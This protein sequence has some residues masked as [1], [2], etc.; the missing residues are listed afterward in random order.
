MVAK[1]RTPQPNGQSGGNVRRFPGGGQN[2]Q[3]ANGRGRPSQGTTLVN[4][5]RAEGIGLF[6]TPEGQAFARVPMGDHRE[7]WAL[8]STGLRLWLERLH[9]QKTRAAASAQAVKEA[10]GVLASMALYDGQEHPV[11]LRTAAHDG[12]IY[13]DLAN[14]HWEIVEIGADIPDGWRVVQALDAPVRFRR[15]KGM[16]ALPTPE[17]GGSLDELRPFINVKDEDWILAKGWLVQAARPT[18]PYISLLLNGEQGTA[19]TSTQEKLRATFDPH[20]HPLRADP[21]DERDMAVGAVNNR[22]LGFDN[23]S[24]LQDWQSDAF[25]R[26]ATG[27]GYATRTLYANDEETLLDMQRPVMLNGIGELASRADLMDRSIV[28][29]T[30]RLTRYRGKADIA[31][32]FAAAHPAILGALCTA[33]A[34]ALRELPNV[35]TSDL[36][37][38]A[39]AAAFVIAAEQAGT[40]GD[41]VA[42]TFKDAYA[43]NRALVNDSALEANPVAQAVL[44]FFD[45]PQRLEPGYGA[46][47]YGERRVS[48]GDVQEWTGTIARLGELL[49]DVTDLDDTL[50][51]AWPKSGKGWGTAL[52][53]AAPN[54]RRKGI[55]LDF[56]VP[57]DGATGRARVGLTRT[58]RPQGE[59]PARPETGTA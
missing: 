51:K 33:L 26:M 18:G 19:K 44:R 13:L 20:T 11:H 43:R 7:T 29:T 59:T 52:R 10:T 28:V 32:D 36:P 55:E 42:G 49:G 1:E 14:D 58:P 23:L 50:G 37:R 48:G 3:G 47:S 57:R 38:M 2:R 5:A 15:T 25:C 24:R 54:L 12:N 8:T 56:D 27:G 9:Y 21:H 34:G 31:R 45:T 30:P 53:R 6:H 39:D 4:L 17:P 41:G 16:Q 46:S 35:D 22:I 40:L